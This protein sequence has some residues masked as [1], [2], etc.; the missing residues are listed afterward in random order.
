MLST[1]TAL[2]QA[3]V[4]S[5]DRLADE[6]GVSRGKLIRSVL[7]TFLDEHERAAADGRAGVSAG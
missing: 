2:P 3:M 5:L 4:D 6:L 1:S 7:A